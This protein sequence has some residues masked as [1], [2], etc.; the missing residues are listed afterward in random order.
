MSKSLNMDKTIWV[1]CYLV[2]QDTWWPSE[3]PHPTR[4]F[5]DVHTY[6]FETEEAAI[7]HLKALSSKNYHIKKTYL[8]VG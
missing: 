1:L 4:F 6:C 5:P 7:E 2:D 3:A 8:Q